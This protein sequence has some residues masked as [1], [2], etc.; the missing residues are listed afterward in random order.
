M[1]HRQRLG[2]G[3]TMIINYLI[4]AL[5]KSRTFE[6]TLPHFGWDPIWQSKGSSVKVKRRLLTSYIL[7]HFNI[8]LHVCSPAWWGSCVKQRELAVLGSLVPPR[9]EKN[10]GDYSLP[11]SFLAMQWVLKMMKELTSIRIEEVFL[12]LGSFWCSVP[13]MTTHLL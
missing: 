11:G 10:I 12:R 9:V 3:D 5:N 6:K 4:I 2:F 7:Q 1:G 13:L 8:T